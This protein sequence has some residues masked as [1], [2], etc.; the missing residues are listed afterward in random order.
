M[1]DVL[2]TERD[3]FVVNQ[4]GFDT[5]TDLHVDFNDKMTQINDALVQKYASNKTAAAMQ[6][7]YNRSLPR[8]AP[9]PKNAAFYSYSFNLPV[10]R[11]ESVGTPGQMS[12][13]DT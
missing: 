11:G 3:V 6:N 10:A 8:N 7:Y 9:G 12:C 13:S 2:Q 4:G 5:H 1:R